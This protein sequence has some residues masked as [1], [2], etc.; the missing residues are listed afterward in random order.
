MWSFTNVRRLGFTPGSSGRPNELFSRP[1]WMLA[2]FVTICDWI[3]CP[4]SALGYQE[5]GKN[6]ESP[7]AKK[8]P[9]PEELKEYLGDWEI[10]SELSADGI[11]S[12]ISSEGVEPP[13]GDSKCYMRVRGDYLTNFGW[14]SIRQTTEESFRESADEAEWT[15]IDENG[16][17]GELYV[18]FDGVRHHARSCVMKVTG[19]RALLRIDQAPRQ[20]KDPFKLISKNDIYYPTIRSLIRADNLFAKEEK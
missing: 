12:P 17:H 1:I 18:T 13:G 6:K 15:H 8:M 7:Q 14:N 19:K 2:I 20:V 10:V 4:S 9:S 3:A 5:P 11:A 16:L